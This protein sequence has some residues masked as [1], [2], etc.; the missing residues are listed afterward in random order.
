MRTKLRKAIRAKIISA[1]FRERLM[2]AVTEVNQCRYCSYAHTKMALQCG[3]TPSEIT[4]ILNHDVQNC[5][6]EEIPA[7]LYAQHWAETE[8]HPDPEIRKRLEK[9]YGHT[10][11]EMIDSILGMIRLANL[12]GNSLD[13]LLFRISFGYWGN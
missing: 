7:I 6:D 12:L 3:L 11:I 2:L 1:E 8:G 5:P 4:N 10:K 9:Q 13:Y